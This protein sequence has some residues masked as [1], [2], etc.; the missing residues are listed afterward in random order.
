VYGRLVD[1][2]TLAFSLYTHPLLIHRSS[3]VYLPLALT[4][5]NKQLPESEGGSRIW[6]LNMTSLKGDADTGSSMVL[7]TGVTQGHVLS[8]F[9]FIL[10]VNTLSLRYLSGVRMGSKSG[11]GLGSNTV[12]K[13]CEGGTTRCFVTT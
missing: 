6:E 5:N 4:I 12:S 11:V 2:S 13:D 3:R 7:N 1:P 8:P 9:L 10:F